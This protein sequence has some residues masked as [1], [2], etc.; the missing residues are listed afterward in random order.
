MKCLLI[1]AALSLG[2]AGACLADTN[3]QNAKGYVYTSVKAQYPLAQHSLGLGCH[4]QG[5]RQVCKPVKST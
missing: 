2:F 1:A 3:T 5:Q 4:T